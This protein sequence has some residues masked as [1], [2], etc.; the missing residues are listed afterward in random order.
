AE[1]D[2]QQL[3][4]IA[5]HMVGR[6]GMSPAIGPIAVL[7]SDGQG[8]LLPGVS[9][10][11]EQTQQL[12]DDEVRRIV[13]SA[14]GE[15]TAALTAHRANLD[16]LVSELLANETLDQ[17][18]AYRAAGLPQNKQEQP[19]DSTPVFHA[20]SPSDPSAISPPGGSSAPEP[21]DTP[22]PGP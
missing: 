18:E 11:S 4:R 13:E 22:P 6:W 8:P 15:T 5:R 20:V 1:S 10:T 17:D 16:G 2:I 14:H 21:H 19:E 9:E 3:T 12:I 7:P